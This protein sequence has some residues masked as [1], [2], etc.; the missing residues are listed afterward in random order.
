MLNL[1]EVFSV[2][3]ILF[4]V[5]DILGNMP[6]IIDLR[7]KAGKIESGKATIAAGLIMILFLFVGEPILKLFGIDLESFAIA[8][9]IILF[10]LGLEMVL[11]RSIFQSDKD[12]TGSASIVPL[13]FP[14]LA[15]AGTMTTI[16]A[17]KSEF[18]TANILVGI[19]LNLAVIYLVLKTSGWLQKKNRTS[20]LW[21]P[22]KGI[23]DN[24]S[25]YSDQTH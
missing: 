20:R 24:S 15:G 6:I 3:L 19:I 1:V 11:G 7:E 25:C 13:A 21:C 10:L 16:I 18:E 12:E 9:G 14:L 2:F 23:W 8:G 5:I 4:S 17:L 22:E